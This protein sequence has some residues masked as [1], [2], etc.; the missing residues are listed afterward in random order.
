[1]RLGNRLLGWII[2]CPLL[3]LSFKFWLVGRFL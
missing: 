2:D 1:M 3:P